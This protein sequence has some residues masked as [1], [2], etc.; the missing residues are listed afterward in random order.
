[1]NGTAAAPGALG[2]EVARFSL[3]WLV[4]AN[5]VGL[6]LASVLLWPAL[7]DLP[8]P[9]TYGR[10][11]PVHLNWQLYG[12]CSLPLVG[13][14]FR[15]LLDGR[16]AATPAHARLALAAWSAALGLGGLSWLAGQVSGK[17]F[18]DWHGWA[19]LPLPAAMTL[20][21]LVLG[22][23]TRRLW[24]RLGR[25]ARL[26]RGAAL[27]VLAAVPPVMIW[28]SS[29]AVYPA[30]N[31]DS[32]G[33]TGAALLGST[34]GIVAIFIALPGLLGL[35]TG[36]WLQR[37]TA[38]W[39]LSGLAW[40]LIR[41]GHTSH[42]DWQQIVALA[43]LLPWVPLLA[44]HWLDCAWPSAARPWIMAALGWWT[45][46]VLSGWLVFLPGFSE[47]AKFSH[48]LVAHAHLAMAGLVTAVNA[49]VLVVL[50]GRGAPRGVLILWNAGCALH[51][52]ATAGLGLMEDGRAAELYRS[53]TWTQ[54][55]MLLR[56]VGGAVMTVGSVR[57]LV[58]ES[59]S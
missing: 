44:W 27:A 17:L 3:G 8:G 53:E 43:L 59:N 32:G 6:W 28:V 19:R 36:R 35:P 57:W 16:D 41:H 15:W 11:M 49:A 4:A 47:A 37:V 21:W 54:G 33:A 50:T 1:M 34:L 58:A 14:L 13:L 31:P 12:W 56:W 9:L 55:W 38:A 10:W 7:G 22:W 39:G 20:L 40:A 24:P 2:R 52:L 18:L 48:V 23:H 29:R 45:L 26:A 46:L 30:V 5:L 42:H 51:V 25:G